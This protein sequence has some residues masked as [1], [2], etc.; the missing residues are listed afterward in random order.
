MQKNILIITQSF[1]CGGAETYI[2]SQSKK[3]KELG[4]NVIIM[5]NG[6]SL[7]SAID[8][9]DIKHYYCNFFQKNIHRITDEIKHIILNE[10]INVVNIHPFYTYHSSIY[11]CLSLNIPYFL[12]LHDKG[13]EIF[14]NGIGIDYKIFLEQIAFKNASKIIVVSQECKEGY[15]KAFNL[16]PDKIYVIENSID[17]DLFK[18]EEIKIKNEIK[19]FLIISRLDDDKFQS[20]V[21]GIELFVNYCKFTNKNLSLRI[22][23]KGAMVEKISKLKD[24]YKDFNIKLL[25]NVTNIYEEIKNNDVIIGMGRCVLEG[26]ALKK[27][28]LLSGYDSLKGLVKNTNIDLFSTTNFSGRN[29]PNKSFSE[30]VNEINE[31]ANQD[32][33]IFVNNNYDVFLKRFDLAKNI[34]II[35]DVINQILNTKLKYSN[36]NLNLLEQLIKINID[37][38]DLYSKKS[39]LELKTNELNNKINNLKNKNEKLEKENNE[40]NNK[41]NNLFN[42]HQNNIKIKEGLEYAIS[43]AKDRIIR[44]ST[45]KI[46]KFVH[47]IYRIK[48]QLLKGSFH[49]KKMFLIW[50]YNSL[51]KKLSNNERKY[52]PLYQ[53]YNVLKINN[54]LSINTVKTKFAKI[55]KKDIISKLKNKYTKFDI[56][57]FGIIDWEY[58]QQRPQQFALQLSSMGHRVYYIN[59]SFNNCYE[60]TKENDNLKIIK[61]SK[62]QFSNIYEAN[63]LGNTKTNIEVE[64]LIK[65]ECITDALIISNYPNWQPI[66]KNLKEKF[67]FFILFDYLDDFEGF[68]T[69]NNK[70]LMFTNETF[71]NSDFVIASSNYLYEKS[72][73]HCKNVEI[74]RNGTDFLHFNKA[75]NKLSKEKERKIIGYYGAIAQWFKV[76]LIKE[77]AINRPEYDIILIGDYSFC[78][79]EDIKKLNN[80]KLLGEKSYQELPNYLKDFDVCIIPFDSDT[81]LIKATNPVKF[82]EYLSAGK[83]IV[84]TNI[85][86]LEPFKDKLVY[87]TNDNKEFLNYIDMCVKKTDTLKPEYELM[88]FAKN[89]DWESRAVNLINFVKSNIPLISIIIVTYN[90]LEYTKKCIFSILNKTAYPSFEIII[91]DNN[92][93][94]ETKNYLIEI[95][96]KYSNIKIVLNNENYGFAKGNNIGIDI[97]NGEYI[98]LLNNDTIVTR[99]WLTNLLKHLKKD[100]N[101]AMVCPVTNSIGNEAKIN[102][103]YVNIE[104]MDYFAYNYVTNNNNKLYNEIDVLAM[105]CIMIKK[106]IIIEVG[107]L[108]ESYGIGM[109]ED[110]DYS[111]SVKE[112]GYKIAC[113]ED[114][115]IHHFGSVSFNKLNDKKFLELFENNKKIFENRFGVKWQHHKYR[116]DVN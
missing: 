41:I 21:N 47:L 13:N 75:Y 95:E 94:D 108:N 92:S 14:W 86:E 97:A 63:L 107:H 96:K 7:I 8:K 25:G 50:L 109:F 27:I 32:I 39:E 16:N 9:Y 6:G 12:T 26:L 37:F 73:K 56:I 83:K 17:T 58:R 72:E 113:A 57:I 82:Y 110:D 87:L 90:N 36:E 65:D 71:K 76:D 77:I 52:N 15:L 53:I 70:L 10:N 23:G 66:I 1:D 54:N 98:V 24:Y 89:Q 78:N 99:G 18:A 35:D 116:N 3:L 100:K 81:N 68:H 31:L 101:L 60:I 102:V 80:V 59:S 11:A 2:F 64:N 106:H 46:F 19:N 43:E 42:E 45:T 29:M 105:F 33:N 114:V 22:A 48:F 30:V 104:D 84:S 62:H 111:Y 112:K 88:E 115:F 91:V 55:L 93:T 61:L 49:E 34:K 44:L 4:Y 38:F 79:I 103:D 74:I 51:I 40:I 69:N 67:G 28:V 5:S 85:P 20:I